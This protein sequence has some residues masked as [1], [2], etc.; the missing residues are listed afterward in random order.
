[1]NYTLMEPIYLSLTQVHLE[2]KD[3][4]QVKSLE[5]IKAHLN[6]VDH[7]LVVEGVDLHPA[8]DLVIDLVV[9]LVVEKRNLQLELRLV[10]TYPVHDFPFRYLNLFFT[11]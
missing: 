3:Q 4:P 11:A 7:L 2:R 1:M 9:D 5:Q 6:I 8:G 10:S